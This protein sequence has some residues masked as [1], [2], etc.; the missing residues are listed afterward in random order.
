MW[1]RGGAAAAR[2]DGSEQHRATDAR[3]NKE[4]EPHHTDERDEVH[5]EADGVEYEQE[6]PECD[7][8]SPDDARKDLLYA[9]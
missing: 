3:V 2:S 9:L 5:E 7:E 6:H 1:R 8:A 4:G